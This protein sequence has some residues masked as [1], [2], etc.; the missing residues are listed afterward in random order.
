MRERVARDAEYGDAAYGESSMHS[1]TRRHCARSPGCAP[2]LVNMPDMHMHPD[3]APFLAVPE[4]YCTYDA[5][6]ARPPHPL[7]PVS[8]DTSTRSHSISSR[9]CAVEDR[10]AAP[11]CAISSRFVWMGTRLRDKRQTP[12]A[13]SLWLTQHP[14]ELSRSLPIDSLWV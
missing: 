13:D 8:P 4:R 11:T 9:S 7:H 6:P 5:P 12:H 3:P 10:E 2:L 14:S 1:H